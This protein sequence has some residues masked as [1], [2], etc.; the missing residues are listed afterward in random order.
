MKRG[1][2]TAGVGSAAMECH[3]LICDET[4]QRCSFPLLSAGLKVQLTSNEWTFEGSVMQN[5]D[6]GAPS[7]ASCVKYAFSPSGC[8]NIFVFTTTGESHFTETPFKPRAAQST[9]TCWSWK[10]FL[11]LFYLS[12]HFWILRSPDNL[13]NP[14]HA[15]CFSGPWVRLR[16]HLSCLCKIKNSAWCL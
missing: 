11:L 2:L 3:T 16:S 9:A 12:R 5:S 15:V 4:T 13:K 6:N 1:I 7:R 10:P 8:C 14:G